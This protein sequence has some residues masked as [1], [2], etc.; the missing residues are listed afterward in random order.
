[1]YLLPRG[2]LLLAMH[3]CCKA[4]SRTDALE[5]M[6]QLAGYAAQRW[7]QDKKVAVAQFS[8]LQ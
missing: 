3:V 6:V 1:M 4:A 7:A 8:R 2:S 5:V